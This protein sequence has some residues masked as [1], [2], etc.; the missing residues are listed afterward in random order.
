MIK[1]DR[2]FCIFACIVVVIAISLATFVGV[3]ATKREG[4]D[5]DGE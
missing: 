4:E 1:I 3:L 5:V 2:I